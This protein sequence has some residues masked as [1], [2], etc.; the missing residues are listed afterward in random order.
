MT[1]AMLALPSG[2]GTGLDAERRRLTLPLAVLIA[3][4]GTVLVF[5]GLA[6][7]YLA[8]KSATGVW[9][10]KDLKY[11]NYTAT[12]L[13]I[14]SLMSSVTIEWAAYG[15]RK[16]FRGQALFGFGITIGLG[17]A[18]LNALYYLITQFGFE[19]ADSPYAT[20]V[21]ALTGL[22]FLVV[23]LALGGVIVTTLRAAGHQLTVDNYQLARATALFWHVGTVGW[24]I[25]FYTIYIT[26]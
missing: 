5:A 15:I 21:Y 20:V 17:I 10:P 1:S 23:V 16:A 6:A 12:T 25:V 13:V 19:A 14:T 26:K 11:D 22:A 18:F 4:A 9:P 3:G 2:A 8:L 24:A 7:A